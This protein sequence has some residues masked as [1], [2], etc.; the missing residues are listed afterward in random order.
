MDFYAHFGLRKTPFTREVVVADLFTH[1][2][3][4]DGIKCHYKTG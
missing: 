1:P 4:Q 3:H 2:Q